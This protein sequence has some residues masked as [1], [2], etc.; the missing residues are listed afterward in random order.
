M[1]SDKVKNINMKLSGTVITIGD[2]QI[3]DVNLNG[4]PGK[5]RA[6]GAGSGVVPV[7]LSGL[8]AG[9]ICDDNPFKPGGTAGLLL[10]HAQA[11]MTFEDLSMLFLDVAEG[12][13]VCLFTPFV[14]GAYDIIGGTGR[15]EDASGYIV[16]EFNLYR[17]AFPLDSLVGAETGVAYGEIVVP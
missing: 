12:A 5:A 3:Y 7:P 6:Q 14:L 9:H 17:S 4:A 15:F 8:P 10:T 2:T 11:T 16:M 1:V 13:Y